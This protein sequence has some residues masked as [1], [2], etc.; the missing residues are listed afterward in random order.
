MLCQLGDGGCVA[1]SSFDAQLLW[2]FKCGAHQG[3][4]DNA[5][6]RSWDGDDLMFHVFYVDRDIG[7]SLLQP[8]STI[9]YKTKTDGCLT[10][11]K[12]GWNVFRRGQDD[13]RVG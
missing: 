8:G 10:V 12:E 9:A 4:V 3:C 6:C 2:F 13:I 5:T 11:D 1:N 7:C